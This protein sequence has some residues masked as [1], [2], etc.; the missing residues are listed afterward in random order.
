MEITEEV[1]KKLVTRYTRLAVISAYLLACLWPLGSFF[2]WIF[3]GAIVYFVFL[4]FYYKPRKAKSKEDFN[5][6]ANQGFFGARDRAASKNNEANKTNKKTAWL[7]VFFM[8]VVMIFISVIILLVSL[9]DDTPISEQANEMAPTEDSRAALSNN[10]NDLDALTN[11][12]NS[13]YSISQYDSAMKYYDRV[14]ELDSKNYSGLFNKALV[15]F[16]LADYNKSLEYFRRCNSLYPEA[17]D[18]H[19][20]I[21]DCYYSQKNYNEAIRWYQQAYE[22]G[23]RNSAQLNI[24][25]YIYDTQNRTSEAIRYYKEALQQDSSLVDVYARLAE[26]EPNRA[27]WYKQKGESWK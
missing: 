21:G 14:L 20:M 27:A 12:G 13:F 15:Y 1:R 3:S 19:N 16:Q 22:G 7:I 9:S 25:A 18:V 2:F 6:Q 5:Y 17:L 4:I 8:F 26:L 24:M 23:T 11:L 10:P